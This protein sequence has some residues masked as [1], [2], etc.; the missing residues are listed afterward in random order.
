MIDA[1]KD[2]LSPKGFSILA[3]VCLVVQLH[4]GLVFTAVT[5]HLENG[6]MAKFVCAVNTTATTVKSYVEKTCFYMY[7]DAYNAPVK[8]YAFVLIS[9]AF[10][11]LV[12][13]IYWLAVSSRVDEANNGVNASGRKTFYVFYFYFFHL[14]LRAVFGILFAILQYT[15]LYPIGF[16]SQ[17]NCVYPTLYMEVHHNDSAPATAT[18]NNP[19]ASDKRFWGRIL[20]ACNCIFAIIA[21]AEVIYLI[22]HRFPLLSQ[23][24]APCDSEFI[25]RYLRGKQ[26]CVRKSFDIYKKTI[27]KAFLTPDINYAPRNTKL[28]DMFVDVVIHTEPSPPKFPKDMQDRH[29]IYDVYKRVPEHSTPI[30]ESKDLFLRLNTDTKWTAP[31]T[32]LA[33]GRPGIGKTVLT[34]KIMCDWANEIHDFYRGKIAFY[35][36]FRQFGKFEDLNLKTFL[37]RG[38]SLDEEE[39]ESVYKEIQAD[40]TK[41]LF[42]FD[43][44]DEAGGNVP[45]FENFL[46][47]ADPTTTMSAMSIFIKIAFGFFL[48]ESTILITS[49]P[50]A[51]DFYSKLPLDRTVEI[52]GFTVI[53]IEEYVGK[54]CANTNQTHLK[55][56]FL[57]HIKS[58]SE[59]ENLCYIPVNCFIVCVTLSHCLDSDDNV[60]PT[61]ITELYTKALYYFSKHHDRNKNEECDKVAIKE[62]QCLAFRGMEDDQLVF[63]E[64]CVNKQ[65]KEFGFLNCLSE[66]IFT[67]QVQ[68]CFIHLSV[69]E[70]LAARHIVETKDPKDIKEFIS[71]HFKIGKWHLV[72]QFLAGLLGS[73]RPDIYKRCIFAFFTKE[74]V[75]RAVENE[76]KERSLEFG[77]M[78]VIKCLSEMKDE[79]IVKEAAAKPP[80]CHITKINSELVRELSP[81]DWAAVS[82]VCKHLNCLA[83][84]VLHEIEWASLAEI[85]KLLKERCIRKVTFRRCDRISQVFSELMERQCNLSH[86]HCELTHL[87]LSASNLSDDGVSCLS[88]FLAKGH[89]RSLKKLDL[90]SNGITSRGISTLC[91][92]LNNENCDQLA[93][94]FLDGNAIG[95]VGV[96]ILCKTLI[97]KQ[98]ELTEIRISECALT[99]ESIEALCEVLSNEHCKLTKL[100]L[101]NNAIRDEGVR[102]LSSVLANEH[103]ELAVL[104]LYDCNLTVNSMPPLCASLGDE[105]S[106]VTELTLVGNAIGGEGVRTL[107]DVLMKEQCKLTVLNLYSCELT[108]QCVESLCAS[109][110]HEHCKLTELLLSDNGIGDEGVRMLS[111]VLVKGHCKLTVLHLSSCELSG[112][113]VRFFCA[114]LED[115][116]CALTELDL[117]YNAIGDE[118]V[119]KLFDALGKEQC[120]LTE[121]GLS[122]CSLTDECLPSL[123]RVLAGNH[124]SLTQLSLTEN[125][126][127]EKHLELLSDTLKQEHCRL[128]VLRISPNG[129]TANGQ[130]LLKDAEQ[131]EHCI[132]RDFKISPM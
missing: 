107:S 16:D 96:H 125:D 131:S 26:Y 33:L 77:D 106:K 2:Y 62:L 119:P 59:V 130:Q 22:Q 29:E 30:K 91:E 86:Q 7:E 6:E 108:A 42:I 64:E 23:S 55:P 127:T 41:A 63:N 95:D 78:L 32:V 40:P 5:V 13:M 122:E 92:A 112:E 75:I 19:T 18:C 109:L 118:L 105:H 104:D 52:I 50:T 58:S 39:F 38:T 100:R 101:G 113:C 126:F 14:V 111:E 94:L 20:L 93:K 31:R 21:L 67:I 83:D 1:I 73:N 3:Y 97:E 53:E 44:L 66:P 47:R 45:E 110:G 15:V 128:K 132:A 117:G 103:C 4:L 99:S 102:M 28:N 72:L 65:M 71:S 85:V 114:A 69:Q 116:H 123:C 46:H 49:R 36:K 25:L 81:S 90:D 70:F 121:L 79:D 88:T 120:E 68:F 43:G 89:G 11:V 34:R 115:E 61:T 87:C 27:L 124:C 17:F 54:F 37:W 8:F 82:F 35:Y 48:I 12:S 84:L 51:I 60:L 129:M 76:S 80:L 9:F 10:P 56:K 24:F 98:F 74:S 57:S